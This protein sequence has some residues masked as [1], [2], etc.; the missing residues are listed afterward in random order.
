MASITLNIP[1]FRLQFPAY[2]D[3]TTYPDT[4]ITATFNTSELYITNATNNCLDEAKLTRSLYLMTAHLL[5]LQ[6]SINNGDATGIVTNATVDKVS[7]TLL[8]PQ[9]KGEFNFWLN[10]SPYGQ[11]LLA[12]LRLCVAG[13]LYVGGAPET[14]VLRKVG[15][16]S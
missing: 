5:F 11:Q 16:Q 2:S 4:I 8:A 3:E 15:G 12:L 6:D 1:D 9:N 13:G 7:V 10:Q 14:R